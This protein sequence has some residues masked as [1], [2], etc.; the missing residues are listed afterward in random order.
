MFAGGITLLSGSTIDIGNIAIPR[1]N[2]ALSDRLNQAA[3][4]ALQHQPEYM[5]VS[6]R[7]RDPERYARIQAERRRDLESFIWI[8]PNQAILTRMLELIDRICAENCWGHAESGFDDP[9]HPVIDLQAAETGMLLAWVLRRH[10]MKL[11]TAGRHISVTVQSEIR[12]RLLS[13]VLAHD[14]YPF[15]LAGSD[16]PALILSDLLLCCVMAETLPSR[17]QPPLKKIMHLL[18]RL[19][20]AP[21]PEG[22]TL[23]RR[24]ADACALAD[25]SRLLKRLTRGELDYTGSVPP[26]A[27]LDD[28]LIPWA[29]GEYF[30]DPMGDGMLPRL[31]GMDFFRLGYTA[32][33]R[34][35]TALGA[36]LNRMR[37]IPPFSLCG[38]I[39]S[40]DC[41]LAI[42]DVQSAPPKL[43]RAVTPDGGIMLSRSNGMLA[44]IFRG[45]NC[46]NAGDIA[47]FCE[48]R[49][50]IIDQGMASVPEISG[51]AQL[52]Q[53]HGT[54]QTDYS[55]EDK[56]DIMSVD[57][58]NAYPENSGIAAYQRTL[59]TMRG[60]GTVRLVD[61]FD[62]AQPPGEITFYF[63]CANRP[64]SLR[65]RVRIGP[66]DLTWD[67][68]MQPVIHANDP[69][70][71]AAGYT[72][73]LT[74]RNVPRRVICGFTFDKN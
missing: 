9:S 46:G 15:M 23:A 31:S 72:L 20:Q 22:K 44:A 47:L 8:E 30:L 19:C 49:P 70:D 59:M 29:G 43:K 51:C 4:E 6:E 36:E 12:R 73:E 67:C 64:V 27:W 18:D 5:A 55:F 38:R 25:L 66:V 65:E 68:D 58:T 26:E 56:R 40:M 21:V 10:G 45:G 16:C 63:S 34:A 11:S 39:L 53:T 37:D 71:P 52:N 35:L 1:P 57:L 3:A 74:L 33:D 7:M 62:F 69:D 50:V 42:Q 61:A 14:D 17:K 2:D 24:L 41:I 13:P 32:H 28:V 60:D 48:G 54:L